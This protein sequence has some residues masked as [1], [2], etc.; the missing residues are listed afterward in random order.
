MSSTMFTLLYDGGAARLNNIFKIN[1]IYIE[2]V[3]RVRTY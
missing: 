2:I 1:S 3:I